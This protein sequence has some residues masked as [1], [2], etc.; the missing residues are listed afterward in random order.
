MVIDPNNEAVIF[1]VQGFSVHD[2]PGGRT[3]VFF[4]GC[5]LRC[6]WCCNPESEAS[7]REVMYRR[8]N[9]TRCY[10][11]IQRGIC[12]HGALSV[13]MPGDYVS[14]DRS[15]CSRC[16]DVACTQQCYHDALKAVGTIYTVEE[17]LRRVQQD[18]SFWGDEGGVTLSGG[19]MAL[20]HRFA[21]AFLKRCHERY[22]RTAVETSSCATWGQL[23]Q[24]Y[25][26]A[27]W[28][29]TDIKHMDD[30]RHKDGT[31][32]GNGIILANIAKTA[33]LARKGRLRH[34]VRVPVI[35]GYNTDDGN[36]AA[37]VAFCREIGAKEVNI[38]P[39]HRMGASK[40]E[41]LDREY[42]CRDMQA[43]S[44]ELLDRIKS[45]FES[46]KIACYKGSDT[47]F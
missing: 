11:C 33:E 19:E 40:Y 30:A 44:D 36:V 6:Y 38:L 23:E 5:P 27:D 2:G 41:Q 21:T 17:L 31:G 47:P 24:I 8:S 20:Q 1:D 34:I 4:K 28:I 10:G 9:C 46:V 43:C 39:F 26:H 16:R 37:T 32:V 25:E 22:I 14:I 3:T 45:R 42:D 12:S 15:V 7:Y 18:A 35:Q 29:F 13:K